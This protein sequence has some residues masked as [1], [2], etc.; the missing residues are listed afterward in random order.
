MRP[1]LKL[2]RDERGSFLALPL[3]ARALFGQLLKL[4]DDDGRI[5]LGGM[6]PEAF[7]ARAMGA[8]RADRRA[9]KKHIPALLAEGCVRLEAGALVFPGFERHQG[10]EAISRGRKPRAKKPKPDAAEPRNDND[11]ASTE[12]PTGHDHVATGS[13]PNHEPVTT[14][15]RTGHDEPSKPPESFKPKREIRVDKKRV[16]KKDP[17]AARD[18]PTVSTFGMVESEFSKWRQ[19]VVSKGGAFKAYRRHYDECTAVAE[20]VDAEAT[21]SGRP[22]V[23][24]LREL[25]AAFEKNDWARS[26]GFPFAA[27]A[28]DPGGVIAAASAPPPRD[29]EAEAE[30][31][32]E[33]RAAADRKAAD[34]HIKKLERAKKHGSPKEES[35][36]HLGEIMSKLRPGGAK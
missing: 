27:L 14:E 1:W 15:P 3:V 24:V 20:Y 13:R 19:G 36:K 7:V 34:D 33:R 30:K 6:T 4:T 5:E 12:P 35:M 28:K 31:R 22:R 9:L 11:D 29:R 32:A 16:D 25:L 17:L 2:Y 8:D 10:D 26:K 18:A 21:G 23:E